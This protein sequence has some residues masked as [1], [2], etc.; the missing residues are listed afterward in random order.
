VSTD[1]VKAAMEL[2]KLVLYLQSHEYLSNIMSQ[3]GLFLNPD[4]K[5]KFIEILGEERVLTDKDDLYC[6]SYDATA[7]I[8]TEIPEIVLLPQ[9]TEQVAE[10]IKV[11]ARHKIPVYPRG[12]GTNLSGGAIPLQKGILLSLLDL[13]RII[14]IDKENLTARVEA[15]VVIQTLVDAADKFGLLYPPDPGTVQ[16]ATMGGSVAECSGGLR[17]LKYG[18]T[19]DYVMGVKVVLAD[20]SIVNFGGKTVKNV[21]GFDMKAI[22]TGSEGL[23]GIITEILVK[24]IPKPEARQAM[25]VLYSDLDKA[26]NTIRE[27]IAGKIIPATMEIIDNVTIRAIEDHKKIGLPVEAEAILLIEVDGIKGAVEQEAKKVKEICLGC[28]ADKI[29]VAEDDSKREEIWNA[30]RAALPSLVR[31]RPTAILEDATV[32]RSKIPEMI[33]AVR[34]ISEKYNV[35]IGTFGHAGDGN[36]HPTILT[37]ESNAEEMERVHKAI[38]EIFDKALALGGTLSGEH[39]IGIAKAKFMPRQF[40]EAELNLMKKLKLAFDP[41]NILNPGKVF[42]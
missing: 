5:D 14:E 9:T 10:I 17:G 41:D 21:S 3:G 1:A 29:V 34:E 33:K 28:G 24:L 18:I 35:Q 6:Y 31:M 23:L 20:G 30:R 40:S 13:N 4:I 37:D 15:G 26:A 42:I 2:A 32:P 11:A 27:V 39:G 25:M 12:A 16:T 38:E 36:L 22:F 19:K 8:E 7:D